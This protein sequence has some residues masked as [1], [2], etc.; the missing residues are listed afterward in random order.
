MLTDQLRC[1]VLVLDLWSSWSRPACD[2]LKSV[3]GRGEMVAFAH[4]DGIESDDEDE[5]END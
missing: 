1:L 2:V 3:S 5:D 4:S